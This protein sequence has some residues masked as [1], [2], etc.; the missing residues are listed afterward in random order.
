ML[1]ETYGVF[2][3]MVRESLDLLHKN[4]GMTRKELYHK[5]YR[6]FRE[7]CAVSSRLI[8]LAQTSAWGLRR[9]MNGELKKIPVRFG[10]VIFAIRQTDRRNPHITVRIIKFKNTKSGQ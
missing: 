4:N 10:K 7:R 1:R 6:E 5:I 3:S 2:F 8:C 9:T